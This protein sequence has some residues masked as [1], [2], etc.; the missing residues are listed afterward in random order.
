MGCQ[1]KKWANKRFD[2]GLKE[3]KLINLPAAYPSV[4]STRINIYTSMC[5]AHRPMC[6]RNP[7]R[8]R[9]LVKISIL[10]NIECTITIF[11][12]NWTI[13]VSSHDVIP[14]VRA[15][16]CAHRILLI[17][18]FQFFFLRACKLVCAA[19]L[20]LFRLQSF[21][22]DRCMPYHK[23]YNSK[24][25]WYNKMCNGKR[26]SS[27]QLDYH[28]QLK[29]CNIEVLQ[30]IVWK[31]IN[32][33]FRLKTN[34]NIILY[35]SLACAVIIV[36]LLDCFLLCVCRLC[37]VQ[38]FEIKR[39]ELLKCIFSRWMKQAIDV[40]YVYIICT[41]VVVVLCRQYHIYV[42]NMSYHIPHSLCCAWRVQ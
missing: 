37:T 31:K 40:R 36:M 28:I 24:R 25:V 15:N 4:S 42:S 30:Q 6:I 20:R 38:Q 29:Y 21:D 39:V 12:L 13:F 19:F 18:Q 11:H 5:S 33:I 22:L 8:P 3:G 2:Y 32:N 7:Y 35:K 27:N 10:S 1:I 17:V 34:T 16:L 14:V 23:I 26:Y 41:I 9:S